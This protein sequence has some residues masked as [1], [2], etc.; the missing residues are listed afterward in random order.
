MQSKLG[1]NISFLAS[2]KIVSYLLPLVTLPYFTRVLGVELFGVIAVGMSIQQIVV[3]LCDYGFNLLGPKL[4]NENQDNEVSMNQFFTGIFL[5]KLSIFVL[6][7][8]LTLPFFFYT[9]E[10]EL[11]WLTWSYYL[12]P[13]LFQS[14]I[15]IWLFLGL[16]KMGFIT[17]VVIFERIVYTIIIFA[18]IN[19]QDD[20]IYIP[21]IA[22][23]T[24]FAALILSLYIS[25][26][27]T[28]NFGSPKVWVANSLLRKGW[29]FFYSRLTLLL[30]SRFNVIIISVFI[31]ESAAGYFS[32][33]ERIY[34]AA[35]S[36][37][38]PITD[39]LYPYMVRTQDWALA[40][41][42][43][44]LAVLISIL[45]FTMSVAISDWLFTALFGL[46]FI[47]SAQIFKILSI[48]LSISILS[49]L[50]GYPILGAFG[51]SDVVNRSVLFGALFHVTFLFLAHLVF[52][53]NII[54]MSISLVLTELTVLCY[55]TKYV[56]MLK[57][58]NRGIEP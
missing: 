52:E 57:N 23:C 6:I 22:M 2:I 53:L 55:R 31:N 7:A 14:L 1:A 33:A 32:I 37:I 51:L 34:N 13:G 56:V 19:S 43:L 40:R 10:S 11:K 50:M 27:L 9:I 35:R 26:R 38:S 25:K 45:S 17:V 18:C 4:V 16:E 46:E 12:L 15:P 28:V 49:M 5:V 54:L 3:V 44:S 20:V 48:G 21:L 39:A 36:M 58:E 47:E 8:T 30:Y 41:K 42:M 24:T 29:G